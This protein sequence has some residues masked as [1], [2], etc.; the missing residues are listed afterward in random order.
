M[1]NLHVNRA[2]VSRLAGIAI[3]VGLLAVTVPVAGLVAASGAPRPV[4]PQPPV[5]ATASVPG[6]LAVPADRPAIV[7]AAVPPAAPR[8]EDGAASAA[9]VS[10]RSAQT[11]PAAFS[12]TLMDATGRAM[13]G[14][15]MTLLSKAT[16]QRYDMRS[17]E[18]GQFAIGD[19]PAGEYQVGVQ[20]PG[21]L[22]AQGRVILAA[23]QQL[24]QDV[25]AQI[26]SLEETVVVQGPGPTTAD[27]GPVA[28]RSR[29]LSAQPDTDPCS[30]SAAGGCLTPP[31]KL[32][33]ASPMFPRAHAA[34]GVSGT[35]VVDA[36]VGTDGFLKDLRPNEGADPNFAASALDAV[37][38]WQ[39]SPVRLNGI[40]QECRIKVTVLFSAGT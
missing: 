18:A 38:L 29:V 26:G 17:D 13:P 3:A 33:D 11:A 32:V 20:K 25:V 24:R 27:A 28:P 23:G 40:A 22:S 6:A 36:R 30:Q 39:F 7:R 5:A 16:S 31:R 35:V 37:R 9:P 1:L 12:G 8:P 15:P 19:V 21:F 10:N 4:P 34:D 14:V 2:P